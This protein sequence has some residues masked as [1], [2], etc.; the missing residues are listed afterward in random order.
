MRA[1]QAMKSTTS[2]SIRG[3]RAKS[4]GDDKVLEEEKRNGRMQIDRER[5]LRLKSEAV[6]SA[7]VIL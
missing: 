4:Q 6:I 2:R 7:S 3:G 5:S 1:S